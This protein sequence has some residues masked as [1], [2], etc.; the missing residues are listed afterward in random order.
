VQDRFCNV[1]RPSGIS[2]DR[3]DSAYDVYR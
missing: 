1:S 3:V 2:A